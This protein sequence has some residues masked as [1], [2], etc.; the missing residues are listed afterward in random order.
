MRASW[1]ARTMPSGHHDVLHDAAGDQLRKYRQLLGAE[2]L[3]FAIGVNEVA[4]RVVRRLRCRKLSDHAH[5]HV[6]NERGVHRIA[7]I[8]DAH[9]LGLIR[10]IHDQVARI[11][12]VVNE[13]GAECREPWSELRTKVPQKT[14][15]EF[16]LQQ[17]R[18]F[19][20]PSL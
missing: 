18:Y 6:R 10:S 3:H 7:E 12:V 1:I 11:E 9:D 20:H 15:D 4:Y 8:D 19:S 17:S 5:R 16:R 2:W 14:S 13:L